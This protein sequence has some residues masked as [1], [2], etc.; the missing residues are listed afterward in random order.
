MWRLCADLVD[1]ASADDL[2]QETYL[3]AIPALG[4]PR[5]RAGADLAAGHR[6]PGLRGGNQHPVPR[7]A[8]GR[9]PR[10]HA[11]S[12]P[13]QA[14]E[15]GAQAAA[16]LLVAA[17]EPD[18]RAAFVLTQMLG[19]SYAE[20][21][22]IC[23]CPVGTIRS[24]V[25]RA[26]EDLIAMTADPEELRA[27]DGTAAGNATTRPADTGTRAARV[28]VPFGEK[29]GQYH[30]GLAIDVSAIPQGSSDTPRFSEYPPGGLFF[31]SMIS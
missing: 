30:R 1:P 21:A 20:A 3:R 2:A 24:R 13:G 10:G 31:L 15:P 12:G 29:P 22:A 26:R 5:R 27:G 16:G 8:A 7:Q 19:C 4:I 23:D 9:P 14:P 11:A 28:A 25:A 18:R 17:L 6:P